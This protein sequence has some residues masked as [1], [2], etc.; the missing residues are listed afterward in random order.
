MAGEQQS[1]KTYYE[2]L[3]VEPTADAATIEAAYHGRS[4]R[5]RVGLFDDRPRDMSGPTRVE[6]EEAY[7]VLG[8]PVAR[9][10]YDAMLFPGGLPAPPPQRRSRRVAA[11]VWWVLAVWLLVGTVALTFTW[12]AR[13]AQTAQTAEPRDPVGQ[14]LAGDSVLRVTLTARAAEP[15]ATSTATPTPVATATP[16]PS[17]TVVALASTATATPTV[18]PT[19]TSTPSPSPTATTPPSPPSP[20]PTSTPTP[21]PPPTEPPPPTP[22]PT[23]VPAFPATD[24][25]GT[26]TPVHLR[27]GPGTNYPILDALPFG[28]LLAATG[29]SATVN[30]V[31]WRRFRLK[32]GRTGWVRDLDTF[33]VR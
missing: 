19:A 27:S 31:F 21:E 7:A 13:T 16:A 1:Q 11:W 2:I 10:R 22:T 4:L 15:A 25:I 8:D 29:E 12:R 17:P 20:T 26:R 23:P 9:A 6:V 32:D 30:G 28:T 24:R 5:F 3:G 18:I 14:I 33:P